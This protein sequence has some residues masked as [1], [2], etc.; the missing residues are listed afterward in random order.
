M[1]F[2]YIH[3]YYLNFIKR[4]SKISAHYSTPTKHQV[5][6]QNKQLSR[7]V[8]P[9]KPQ[10]LT[11]TRFQNQKILFATQWYRTIPTIKFEDNQYYNQIKTETLHLAK[12]RETRASQPQSQHFAVWIVNIMTNR[13]D[14]SWSLPHLVNCA[15]CLVVITL[16]SSE[17]SGASKTRAGHDASSSPIRTRR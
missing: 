2:I 5:N 15:S 17:R 4:I 13:E 1:F 6:K 10:H 12:Q 3:K 8:L 16:I 14:A 7:L 9:V 11:N